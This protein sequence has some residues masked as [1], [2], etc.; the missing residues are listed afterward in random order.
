MKSQTVL[1]V[2]L[3]ILIIILVA[4]LERH[5]RW[6]AAI[7]ATMPLGA[8]LALWIVYAS[9]RGETAEVSSFTQNLLLG[10]LPTLGFLFCAWMAARA[11]WRLGPILVTGY[12]AWGAGLLLLMMIKRFIGLT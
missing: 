2:I 1:P 3:S 7:T 11:G 8:P 6:I 9:A 10:I 5:S 4:V 12:A